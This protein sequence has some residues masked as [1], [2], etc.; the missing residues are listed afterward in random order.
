MADLPTRDEEAHLGDGLYVR[1]DGWQILLRAP[2]KGGDH[3]VGLEPPVYRAL[4]EWVARYPVLWE[5]FAATKHHTRKPRS[6]NDC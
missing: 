1:F 6:R 4:L 5:H 3:F 2:R